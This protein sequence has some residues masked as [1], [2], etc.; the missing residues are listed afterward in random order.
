MRIDPS[1]QTIT[2]SF[3]DVITNGM[4]SLLALF[5]VLTMVRDLNFFDV[6]EA[7]LDQPR[8]SQRSTKA[9]SDRPPDKDPLIFLVLGHGEQSLRMEGGGYQWSY[10]DHLSAQVNGGSR[11]AAI[12]LLTP[13]RGGEDISLGGLRPNVSTTIQIWKSGQE[14]PPRAAIVPATGQLTLWPDPREAV[15]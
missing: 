9:G 14:L 8:T 10:P 5:L 2:M 13:L 6:S 3:V 12:T 4:G 15:R 1:D 11:F 7:P